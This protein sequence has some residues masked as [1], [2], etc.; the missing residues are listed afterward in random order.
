MLPTSQATTAQAAEQVRERN[1]TPHPLDGSRMRDKR[2]MLDGIAT[3][4][5]FPEWSGR[6]L[7]ALYDCLTDLSW[8]PPGEHVLIWSGHRALSEHD[9]KG[10]RAINTVL[11][12]ASQTSFA[13]RTFSAVL[14]ED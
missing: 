10:F 6:N 8:L 2:R 11:H 7:D 3:A 9:P 1:G 12:D 5:S 13:G 14:T 4:L